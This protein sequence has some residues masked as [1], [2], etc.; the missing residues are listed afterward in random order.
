MIQTELDVLRD[1]SQ[2]LESAGISF[3]LTSAIF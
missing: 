2:R 3:M 1:V